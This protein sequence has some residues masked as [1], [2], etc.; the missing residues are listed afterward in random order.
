MVADSFA[1]VRRACIVQQLLRNTWVCVRCRRLAVARI[2][3]NFIFRCRA[4]HAGRK[5]RTKMT[6][7]RYC[8]RH[9]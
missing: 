8:E 2:T 9:Y 5:Q 7:K 3:P 4:V 6:R 1:L